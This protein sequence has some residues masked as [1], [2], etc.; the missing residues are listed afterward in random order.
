VRDSFRVF[1][2]VL[3]RFS[4]L[5][6]DLGLARGVATFRAFEVDERAI[7]KV[8]NVKNF[9]VKGTAQPQKEIARDDS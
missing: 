1:V 3:S 6:T 8:R 7:K 2:S 5:A 9:I 4:C